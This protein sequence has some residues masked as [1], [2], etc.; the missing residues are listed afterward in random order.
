MQW[1]RDETPPGTTVAVIGYPPSGAVVEWF[2]A[3]AGRRNATTAQGTEWVA[4]GDRWD[5]ASANVGCRSPGCLPEAHL[6]VLRPIAARDSGALEAVGPG[7]YSRT[8]PEQ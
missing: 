5:E 3:L 8:R 1:V 7:V 4:D 6:Y 2:P